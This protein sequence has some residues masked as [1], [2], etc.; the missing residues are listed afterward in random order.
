MQRNR[1][2]VP[3][4]DPEMATR[5]LTADAIKGAGRCPRYARRA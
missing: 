2:H 1:K 4:T 5:T 3:M